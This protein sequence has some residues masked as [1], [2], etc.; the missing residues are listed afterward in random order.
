MAKE[1]IVQCGKC[2]KKLRTD[3]R[4]IGRTANCPSCG[5][6]IRVTDPKEGASEPLGTEL[7]TREGALLKLTKQNDVGVITF[8]TTRILDQSNVMQLGDEF[9]E[10][11]AK[12]KLKKLVLNFQN[13]SYMSSAVMGKL[14]SLHK[15]VQA[16]DGDMRLCGIDK[17]IYEIFKIMRFDKLFKISEN[18]DKAVAELL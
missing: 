9:E 8:T 4:H 14:V 11:L 18:E 5:T 1:L 7:A 15:K 16:Q 2:G 3:E 6:R 12:H 13:V 17:S 10:I